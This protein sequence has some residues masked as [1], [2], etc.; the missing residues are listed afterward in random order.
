MNEADAKNAYPALSQ[1]DGTAPA[2]LRR[3]YT[4]QRID[5]QAHPIGYS[6]GFFVCP[7]IPNNI[8]RYALLNNNLCNNIDLLNKV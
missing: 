3:F 1:T 5:A 8:H 7:N 2:D 6:V 4:I